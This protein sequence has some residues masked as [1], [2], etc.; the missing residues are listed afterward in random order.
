MIIGNS[1]NNFNNSDK[2]KAISGL[3]KNILNENNKFQKK[4]E[5]INHNNNK[6]VKKRNFVENISSL[7]H[8]DPTSKKDMHTKS[9][10]MLQERLNN[11]TITLE[12]FNKRCAALAKMK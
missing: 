8:S 5:Q 1:N 2:T 9:L 12:E 4:F 10:A 7:Q 3:N 11:G 6:A